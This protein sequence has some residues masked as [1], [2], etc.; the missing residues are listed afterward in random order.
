MD[1]L[2]LDQVSYSIIWLLCFDLLLTGP[3]LTFICHVLKKR[4]EKQWKGDK[5]E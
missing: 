3:R 4:G 1:M 5:I 2:F